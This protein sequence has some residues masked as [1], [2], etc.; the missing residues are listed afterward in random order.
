[1]DLLFENCHDHQPGQNVYI[2]QLSVTEKIVIV[3]SCKNSF[4]KNC[5]HKFESHKL[6]LNQKIISAHFKTRK[7]NKFILTH[8]IT[9]HFSHVTARLL[10]VNKKCC[11]LIDVYGLNRLV[12][13]NDRFSFRF[14]TV[15]YDIDIKRMK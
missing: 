12:N 1:M 6:I 5:L 10:I 2:F 9:D 11:R 13:S 15:N 4:P 7:S 3:D 14:C 8:K